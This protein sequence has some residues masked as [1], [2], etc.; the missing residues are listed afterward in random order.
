ML[1]LASSMLAHAADPA[2]VNLHMRLTL[3]QY[4][5]AVHTAYT[6]NVRHHTGGG[7]AHCA[8]NTS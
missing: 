3:P 8:E 1:T 7:C 4:G 5:G 2:A 6:V